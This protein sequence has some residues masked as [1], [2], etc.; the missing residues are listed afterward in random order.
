MMS[1]SLDH[2]LPGAE[3]SIR[4]AE[5]ARSLRV[6]PGGTAI[7]ADRIVLVEVALPWPK[8]ALSHPL[9]VELAELARESRR[10]TRVLLAVPPRPDGPRHI[11]VFDRVEGGAI[12]SRYRFETAADAHSIGQAIIEAEALDAQGP[13]AG[14][15]PH[16]L[17]V[18]H[19]PIRGAV[20]LVCTQGSHDV[21]C[22]S[23]GERLAGRVEASGRSDLTLYRVSHTGGHRFAPTAMTLPDGRMWAG[24]DVSSLLSIIDRSRDPAVAAG[25]CRGW[26]GA[27]T[28]QPQVAERAVFAELGWTLDGHDRSVTGSTTGE[29]MTCVIESPIGSWEVTVDNGRAVP[30]IAC[31]EPGGQPAKS[32]LEYVV[33]SIVRRQR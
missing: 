7:R 26:W 1:T 19:G 27:E 31:R 33:T 28:G 25:V 15:A 6:D 18:D 14:P 29:A 23:E 12:E 13:E 21:C 32:G 17:L 30:T 10:P 11:V 8:P 3:E 2:L 4:C 24:L 22:G 16:E 5:F 9:V 20:V